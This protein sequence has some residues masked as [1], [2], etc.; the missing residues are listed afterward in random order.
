MHKSSASGKQDLPQIP[1]QPYPHRIE[2]AS[3][4]LDHNT[5]ALETSG[6]TLTYIHYLLACRPELQAQLREELLTLAPPILY[7]SPGS[8]PTLPDPKLLDD[9]PLLDAIVQE[10]LR[11]YA[12]APGSQPRA[13]PV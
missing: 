8:C 11:L 10:T 6:V 12:P 13:T 3:E 9:L 1:S 5:A 4:M 2:I 7:P